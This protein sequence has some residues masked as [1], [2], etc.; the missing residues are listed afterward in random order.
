MTVN[1]FNRYKQQLPSSKCPRTFIAYHG[2]TA[3]TFDVFKPNYRRGEELGF[4]IHFTTDKELAEMYAY[5]PNVARK[6]KKPY[7]FTASIT[8]NKCLDA[9]KIVPQGTYEFDL[10]KKIAGNKLI[11][12]K[13]ENGI[14]TTYLQRAIDSASPQRAE[15]I[16]RDEGYDCIIYNV[17]VIGN[18]GMSPGYYNISK[19]A[20][21]IIVLNPSQIKRLD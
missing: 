6:G 15:K 3:G 21:G 9:R 5:N 17:R 16:L 2:T 8:C 14:P 13:D 11:V 20:E 4:G 10:A 19:E 7:V 18:Y 1:P 12:I